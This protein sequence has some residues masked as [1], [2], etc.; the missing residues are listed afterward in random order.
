MSRSLSDT[1]VD[2]GV[3]TPEQRDK[4]QLLATQSKS[5]FSDA[6][7]KLGFIKEEEVAVALSKHFGIPFASR[8]NKI[9]KT[10]S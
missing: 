3:I 6:A 2:T 5:Q 1:L 4:A 10:G 7:I 8:E 9:L